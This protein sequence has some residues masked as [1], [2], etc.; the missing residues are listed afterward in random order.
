MQ[1][2]GAALATQADSNPAFHKTWV[3][4]A[5]DSY[6]PKEDGEVPSKVEG[7]PTALMQL[8]TLTG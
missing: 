8:D 3:P 6:K 7:V 1:R 5:V 4:F 2:L